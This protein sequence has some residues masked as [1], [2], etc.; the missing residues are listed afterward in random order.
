MSLVPPDSEKPSRD[1]F[2]VIHARRSVRRFDLKRAVP[3]ALVLEVIDAARYTPSSCNLQTWDFVIVSDPELRKRLAEET[4]SVQI[5]PVTIFVTYDKELAREGLANVQ[6]ASAAVMTLLLAATARGLASL[7]VNALGDRENVRR[8]LGVPDDYEVLAL[9]CLGYPLDAEPPPMPDRRPL[10]EVVHR[11]RYQGKGSL[12][13]SP[14][15]DEWSLSELAL[16]FKRKLQSGTRYNKPVVAFCD[17]VIQAVCG[18]MGSPRDG[19]RW[20][21]VLPGTAMFTELLHAK[22]PSAVLSVLEFSAE[23]HFFANRRCGGRVAFAPFPLA[24]ADALLAAC[25]KLGEKVKLLR[26]SGGLIVMPRVLPFPEIQS[27]PVDVATI[28][29][30][31]EG[32]PSG[33]RVRLLKEVAARLAP[34]G[35]IVVAFVSRRSWHLPAYAARR[36]MGRNSV[37]VA[38]APEPNIIGP[39]EAL[40]PG[41][42]RHLAEASGLEVVGEARLLPLP[43][44]GALDSVVRRTRGPATWFL[45]F[46]RILASAMTP[47]SGLLRPFSRVRVLCLMRPQEPSIS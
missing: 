35:R 2:D 39:F 19:L 18:F 4:K 27:G 42:V 21:D 6:S 25:A 45:R 38:P 5:A 11:E 32:I 16:Y 44:L 22:Y 28:L 43:D 7:W 37:E 15:P 36:R 12:P 41:V 47:F 20:L 29:F 13:R 1:L 26:E 30:R 8:I 9:V 17:P 31:L 24:N 40:S 10:A 46:A 3:D 23:N 34:N 14:N 33:E